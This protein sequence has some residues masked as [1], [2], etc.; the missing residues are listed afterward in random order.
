MSSTNESLLLMSLEVAVSLAIF[1][2]KAAGGLDSLTDWQMDQVRAYS[3]QLGGEGDTL[4]FKTKGKTAE[5][6][7]KLTECL[8]IMAF[9]PG[10]V[11]IAG[12]HFEVK[13]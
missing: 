9:F 13:E 6:F 3:D 12:L 7:T 11:K 8:A 4:L 2:L 1:D 10:G 5:N